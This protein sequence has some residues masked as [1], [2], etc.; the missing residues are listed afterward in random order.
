MGIRD[1]IL[2]NTEVLEA[3]MPS[4]GRYI[5]GLESALDGMTSDRNWLAESNETLKE[6]L[7]D[8]QLALEDLGWRR[9]T[10]SGQTEFTIDGIKRGSELCRVMVVV[11]PLIKRGCELRIAYIWGQGVSI[12]AKADGQEDGEQNVNGVL[13]TF[14]DDAGNQR[15]LFGATAREERERGLLTDGNFFAA[16]YTD[17]RSGRVQAR[18]VPLAEVEDVITNPDDRSEPWYYKRTNFGSAMITTAQQDVYTVDKQTTSYHP[19][20]GYSPRAKPAKINGYPVRW[21]APIAHLAVNRLDG[22]KFGIGDA[23]AALGWSRAYKEYLEDWARLMKSLARFAWRATAKGRNQTQVRAALGSAPTLDPITHQP[24]ASGATLIAPEGQGLEAIPKTGATIDAESGRPLAAMTAA[25]LG[26]PV[27]WLLGDPGITGARATAETLDQPSQLTM[28]GR[29][30]VWAAFLR[31]VTDYVIDQAIRAPQGP[32]DG[33]R[34]IDPV[35]GQEVWSLTGDDDGSMRSVLIEFPELDDTALNLRVQAV[36]AADTTGKLPPLTIT[37]LLADVFELDN[38]DEIIDEMT[39]DQGNF[40]DPRV[41]AGQAAVDAF[42][43]G[44]DPAAVFGGAQSNADT[45]G[46]GNGS[47]PAGSGTDAAGS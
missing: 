30:G 24:N 4:K 22:W 19:A 17:P 1:L 28:Q 27:T 32:L 33:T 12:T 20:L 39:D 42:R 46:G 16:L 35:T 8:A 40:V 29:Q 23:Y 47:D 13:Q 21:D 34:T 45:S 6:S 18:S 25:A 9:L 15:T 2:G 38:V 36:V 44:Q 3:A 7:A 10:A 31:R 5:N 37:R 41:N 43:Q 26:I 14:M 11:N